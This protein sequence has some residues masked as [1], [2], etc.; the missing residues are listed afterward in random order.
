M[1]RLVVV[2]GRCVATTSPSARVQPHPGVRLSSRQWRSQRTCMRRE[3]AGCSRP[4]NS[5][6]VAP[7]TLSSPPGLN[8]TDLRATIQDGQV[9]EFVVRS[10]RTGDW[11]VRAS[12]GHARE[13]DPHEARYWIFVDLG[14]ALETPQFYIAPEW[15]VQNNIH[16]VNRDYLARHGGNRARTPESDHRRIPAGRIRRWRDEWSL[17]GLS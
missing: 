1:E 13:E 7:I 17:L 6:G 16:E 12:A 8:G 14:S 10:R 11:Q 3:L 9:L 2:R 15:W 4:P 5:H